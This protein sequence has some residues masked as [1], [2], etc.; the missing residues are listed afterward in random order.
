MP[1][2]FSKK[3]INDRLRDGMKIDPVTGCWDWQ[4]YVAPHGYGEI[5]YMGEKWNVHRLAWEMFR[6][7]I[8]P[9][10]TIDH[11]CRNRRCLNPDHLEPVSM[12]E[13]LARGISPSALNAK[14]T[15]CAHGHPL[16]GINLRIKGAERVCIECSRISWRKSEPKRKAKRAAYY[17]CVAKPRIALRKAQGL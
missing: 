16:S 11:L 13:N 6:G 17:Q 10:L 14:K 3:S 9:G 12:K 5:V 1:K 4:K 8:E 7:P 15:H 2:T